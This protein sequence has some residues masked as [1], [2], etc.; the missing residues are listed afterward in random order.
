MALHLIESTHQE[1][2]AEALVGKLA[3][4]QESVDEDRLDV[5]TVI[6]Q[7]A[8]LGRWLRLWHARRCGISAAVKMPFAQSFI[9][10]ELEREG[11]FDRWDALNTGLLRWRIFGILQNRDFENVEGTGLLSAYLDTEHPRV[12]SRAWALS[13]RLANLYDR[14]AVHRPEWI[15]SWLRGEC[16]G[17]PL[18]HW[19]WQAWLFR[20]VVER[21]GLDE[22]G[23]RRRFIGLA[24]MEYLASKGS[25]QVQS[26][27]PLHVFG[28][29]SFPPVY[30][31]FFQ[32]LAG[33][34][35]VYLYHLIPSEAYL[36]DLPKN[37][38]AHVLPGLDSGDVEVDFS[39][40]MQN[41]LLVADGQAAARFQSLLL[42]LD[43][44]TGELPQ[45]VSGEAKSDLWAMQAA[46]RLNEPHCEFVADGT[47]SLHRCHSRI[48]EVQVLQQQLL[49]RFAVD[50]DLRPEDV[51]VLVPEIA[52]YTDAIDSVFG[53]GTRTAE[54]VEP[55]KIPYCLADQRRSGDENCW[56]FFTTLLQLLKGRQAF[57][58]VMA[59]LDFDPV[60]ER[61]RM[62]RDSFKELASLLQSV[63]VR[64]GI[65]RADRQQKG[66]PDYA[67]YSWDYGLEQIY[68]GLIFGEWAPQDQASRVTSSQ[69]VELIGS[70]TQF[71]RPIF[72]LASE[73]RAPRSFQQW[74]EA[75]LELLKGALGDDH[76][77]GE[78]MRLLSTTIGELMSGAADVPIRFD[79]FCKI[80]ETGAVK[81][82]GP[83]GLLRRGVT[84]CRLQPAR[85]I[86]AKM[87]CILGL[88]EGSYPRQDPVFEFD[89]IDAQRRESKALKGTPV[90]Y[91]EIHYIGDSQMRDADRQLFLECLLNARDYLYLS[92]VGQSVLSNEALPPS[93]LVSELRQFL[94]QGPDSDPE[95]LQARAERVEQVIVRHPLQDWSLANFK[96]PMPGPGEPPVPVH[97]NIQ[98]AEMSQRGEQPRAFL[99]Y[100]EA[101]R[102]PADLPERLAAADLLR[103]LKDPAGDY[104]RHQLQVKLEQL[105]WVETPE[106]EECFEQDDLGRWGLRQRAFEEWLSAKEQGRLSEHFQADLK[107]KLKLKL[108]LPPGHA[109]ET[110][111]S[112]EVKPVLDALDNDLGEATLSKDV[113]P[114]DVA[115]I[116]FEVENRVLEDGRRVLFVGGD[117]KKPKYAL[118]AF[119]GHIGAAHGSRI[120]CLKDQQWIDWPPFD[121]S[122]GDSTGDVGLSWLGAVIPLWYQGQRA[123]LPFSLEIGVSYVTALIKEE[124]GD[125]ETLLSKAYADK[126]TTSREGDPQD[127]SEAQCLCFDGDSPAAPSAS[128]AMRKAFAAH[129][130]TIFRPVLEW[131]AEQK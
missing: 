30:L 72:E 13:E 120:L 109:G 114:V 85:H 37:Y 112:A 81:E 94:E 95:S 47:I 3:A 29:S 89:L 100:T 123:P 92:Y 50:P 80:M 54:G 66:F 24:L 58:D 53:M 12:E 56:R 125:T 6:V 116:T 93:L 1:A 28:I 2:L 105:R 88:D 127:K 126:W 64:W 10:R 9:A 39:E 35:D 78:W 36:G 26:D 118:Q 67:E 4:G 18:A 86:P 19:R 49:A 106:D 32:K 27:E 98:Y 8:G 84:F 103:F 42:T 82:R 44:P 61:L 16:L 73:T 63:G 90:E 121:K 124:G 76:S 108:V 23:L 51:I 70:L 43:I 14:Y 7:N 52:D 130:E 91:C 57:S 113:F 25:S 48:R 69:L 75:I 59:L 122:P 97:F 46:I 83:S 96:H 110:Q 17:D 87:I 117:L 68:N 11:L 41:G 33:A 34:R 119:I 45:T 22:A 60:C 104:L 129:A 38:R 107:Q 74:A 99:E 21:M 65:D 20:A 40:L 15:E 62:D 31:R 101:D 111:W 77:G 128:E 71:L 55:V 131:I 102:P 79:T 5:S 115:G